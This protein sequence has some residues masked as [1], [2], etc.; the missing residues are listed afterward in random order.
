M[1]VGHLPWGPACPWLSWVLCLLHQ[2]HSPPLIVL[3]SALEAGQCGSGCRLALA[4][5]KPS[6]ASAVQ[7]EGGG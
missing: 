5:G 6:T 3:L 7:K 4:R 1:G 2:A